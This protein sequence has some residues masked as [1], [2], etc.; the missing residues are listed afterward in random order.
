MSRAVRVLISVENEL[1]LAAAG[2]DAF[3]LGEL[4]RSLAGAADSFSLFTG[5]FFGRLFEGP[6]GLHFTEYAFALQLLF[7]DAEGLI[8]I[9]IADEDLQVVS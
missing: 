6:A 5:A 4:A 3:A 1:A 8:D 7:Q 2:N 9:V